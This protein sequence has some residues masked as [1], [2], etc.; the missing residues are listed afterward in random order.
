MKTGR[1]ASAKRGGICRPASAGWQKWAED[2]AGVPGLQAE[3]AEL[4]ELNPAENDLIAIPVRRAFSLCVW[5]PADDPSVFR[6]LVLTQLEMRGL[7][8]RTREDTTF[9]CEE[10]TRAEN[11]VLVQVT[12]LPAHLA[13]R[14]WHGDVTAYAISPACLP[15]E[16]DSVTIWREQGAWVTAVTRG[17]KLL[18]FQSL[19]EP[20]ADQAMALEV[21]IMLSPLEAGNMIEPHPHI[22]FYRQDGDE[23]E[24]AAWSQGEA[25][26]ASVRDFPPPIRPT[27]PL[28]SVPLAVRDL[29][30]QKKKSAQRQRLAFAGAAV[31]LALVLLLAGQTLWLHWQS[32]R[33]QAEIDRDAPAVTSTQEAMNKWQALQA[34]LEP[35]TYPLEVL[36]QVAQLLPKDGVRLTLFETNLDRVIIQGEA[37][38]LAAAI[39]LQDDL[40]KNPE[41]EAL[42]EWTA[43]A[44]KQLPNGSTRFQ[45]D[46][47]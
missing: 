36:F 27:V 22:V 33:L 14:Y 29:Q 11:E 6:D 3:A 19:T 39:K 35:T 7:A 41:L 31:Y 46:G 23:I 25:S 37:S 10:I 24:L 9:S 2:A 15:L 32:R 4:V 30:I 8:G 18:H 17:D 12:V 16:K 43:E 26:Q 28:G 21:W 44:P 13:S 1:D 40:K 45:I 38:T 42:Y 34:T 5:I 20:S 47:T